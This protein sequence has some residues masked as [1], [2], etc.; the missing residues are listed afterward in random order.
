M[1]LDY[2]ELSKMDNEELFVTYKS[3]IEGISSDKAKRLLKEN[4]KNLAK[5]QINK[6]WYQFLLE[7][8]NDKFIFILILLAIIDFLL[9]DTLGSLIIIAIAIVSALIKFFQNYSVY[10]F[11]KTLETKI[12]S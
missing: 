8:F 2:K 5:K 11:N 10:K 1:D 4:G 9:K 12:Y 6:K 7:S 3:K